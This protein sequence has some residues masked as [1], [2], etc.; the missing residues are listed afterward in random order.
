MSDKYRVLKFPLFSLSSEHLW[1]LN[2]VSTERTLMPEGWQLCSIAE[3]D[4]WIVLW[5]LCPLDAPAQ[6]AAFQS[7]FTGNTFDAENKQFLKTIQLSN[8]LVV[9]ILRVLS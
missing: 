1:R 4:G 5:A 8:G 3:Q 2:L 6:R 7:V 9:H